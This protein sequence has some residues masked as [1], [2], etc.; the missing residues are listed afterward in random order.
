[1]HIEFTE[2]AIK[3]LAE[4]AWQINERNENIGARRLHTVMERLLE[5]LSYEATELGGTQK[6]ID[7]DDVDKQLSELVKDQDLSQYI[8]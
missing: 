3:R 8:L 4:I 2:A 6:V 5:E 1:M 7:T